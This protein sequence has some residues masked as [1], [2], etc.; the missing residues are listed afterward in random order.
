MKL[1][2]LRSA[3]Y[4]TIP[5]F[6][7]VIAAFQA[8]GLLLFG[9]GKFTLSQADNAQSVRIRTTYSSGR[10]RVSY[11]SSP[12]G[13]FIILLFCV[14]VMGVLGAFVQISKIMSYLL[15]SPFI[16][17]LPICFIGLMT[18]LIN[19]SKI[20]NYIIENEDDESL[21]FPSL[22]WIVGIAF[23]FYLTS[24]MGELGYLESKGLFGF[25]TVDATTFFLFLLGVYM[26]VMSSIMVLF[27]SVIRRDFKIIKNPLTYV[28]IPLLFAA[29]AFHNKQYK[30]YHEDVKRGRIV[31]SDK[32]ANNDERWAFA[33]SFQLPLRW[34]SYYGTLLV[35]SGSSIFERA[36]VFLDN[37]TSIKITYGRRVISEDA[38]KYAIANNYSIVRLHVVPNL[39]RYKTLVLNRDVDVRD[40]K[41]PPGEYEIQFFEYGYEPMVKKFNF[42]PGLNEFVIKLKKYNPS[43]MDAIKKDF[44]ENP[45]KGEPLFI[46]PIMF[47][48]KNIQIMNIKEKFKNGIYLPY[49]SYTLKITTSLREKIIEYEHE[50][51][52][53]GL[54]VLRP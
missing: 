44:K 25:V 54:R 36:K 23:S 43:E 4:L 38:K 11:Q 13:I 15:V 18:L 31:I 42:K 46:K 24:M 5:F 51:S 1:K 21:I 47:D 33:E 49:G 52:Y 50:P 26:P 20:D 35:D 48:V 34:V 39:G 10:E 40:N 16:L 27:N 30:D 22:F 29:G 53:R 17:L 3:P 9:W 12:I 14:I 7:F 28:F 32:L 8:I 19:K 6:G 41:V 45:R 37:E 2:Y